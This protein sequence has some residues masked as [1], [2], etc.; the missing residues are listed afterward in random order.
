MG[1]SDDNAAVKPQRFMVEMPNDLYWAL[2][3]RAAKDRREPKAEV[4]V[5]VEQ[6]L[7]IPDS[8]A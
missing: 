3:E 1:E 8:A 6:F 5:A 2:L 4:L 7:A